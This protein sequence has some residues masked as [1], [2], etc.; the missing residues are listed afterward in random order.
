MSISSTGPFLM[1]IPG[2][3]CTAGGFALSIVL[4]TLSEMM[5]L[6]LRGCPDVNT[7]NK[8]DLADG[9]VSREV[10]QSNVE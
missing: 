1:E 7:I 9:Q 5:S 3:P 10:K 2:A 6:D 4:S 8:G